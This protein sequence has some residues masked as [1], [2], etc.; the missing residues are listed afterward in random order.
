MFFKSLSLGCLML[1]AGPLWADSVTVQNATKQLLK[2]SGK[3]PA[4]EAPKTRDAADASL[5]KAKN[6]RETRERAIP[7]LAAPPAAPQDAVG[8]SVPE[9]AAPT[10]EK[11]TE[12]AGSRGRKSSRHRS[13]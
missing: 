9:T 7:G 10:R 1:V 6:Q 8:P 2:D 12:R 13:E 4:P 5:E 3:V 11:K